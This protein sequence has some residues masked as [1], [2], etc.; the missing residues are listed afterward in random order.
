[1]P[2]KRSFGAIQRRA[3]KKFILLMAYRD[4]FTAETINRVSVRDIIDYLVQR[5]NGRVSLGAIPS[6][7]VGEVLHDSR[8]K[9]SF[10]RCNP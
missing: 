7:E 1:M 8:G 5:F 6:V 3:A 9:G 4:K 2:H 10:Q